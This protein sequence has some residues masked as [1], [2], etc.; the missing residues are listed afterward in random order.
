VQFLLDLTAVDP[1]LDLSPLY[2]I[3][4]ALAAI[5]HAED[6]TSV[7]RQ[8]C[9]ALSPLGLLSEAYEADRRRLFGNFPRAS[10]HASLI[11]AAFAAS[12][13][14]AEVL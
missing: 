1:Q 14:W 8:V 4:E 7:M 13:R 12:P 5:G 10:S 11:R 6:A 3:D 2:A 9:A